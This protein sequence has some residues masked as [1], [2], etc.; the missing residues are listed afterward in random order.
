M[1]GTYSI[2]TLYWTIIYLPRAL[3]LPGVIQMRMVKISKS[4]NEEKPVD[5]FEA[6][7]DEDGLSPEE[8][9]FIRGWEGAY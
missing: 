8:E 2:Y 1:L 6:S 7:L 4:R 9:A 5:N 3:L